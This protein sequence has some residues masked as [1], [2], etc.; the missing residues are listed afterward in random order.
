MWRRSNQWERALLVTWNLNMVINIC[1]HLSHVSLWHIA[2]QIAWSFPLK[3]TPW[4]VPQPRR[5]SKRRWKQWGFLYGVMCTW[6][7]NFVTLRN[8]SS[9]AHERILNLFHFNSAFL[10]WIKFNCSMKKLFKN[11]IVI[12]HWL[13]VWNFFPRIFHATCEITLPAEKSTPSKN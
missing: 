2:F 9:P 10:R 1:R 6:H 5:S 8:A 7:L 12:S 13:N 4:K 11:P 3:S